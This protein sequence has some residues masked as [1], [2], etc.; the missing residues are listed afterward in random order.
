MQALFKLFS[1]LPLSI[2]YVFGGLVAW[3][4]YRVIGYRKKVVLEN[5]RSSFPEWDEATLNK[6]CKEFY[7][8]LGDVLMETLKALTMSEK[9]FAKRV[10]ITNKGLIDEVMDRNLPYIAAASHC[11]NWEWTLLGCCALFNYTVD[12]AYMPV[13]NQAFEH[14][15][16]SIRTRFGA[17]LI[18]GNELVKKELARRS[19]PRAICMVADQRPMPESAYWLKFLNK[20]TAAFRGIDSMAKFL[21]VNI[22][23][24]A[25]K[26]K[27]RGY[28]EITLHLIGEPPYE[29][30]EF[31]ILHR[32]YALTEQTIREDPSAWL[33]THKRWKDPKPKDA[34]V[35]TS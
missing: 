5:M 9:E 22:Y 34:V 16:Y 1:R 32:F 31:G 11:G 10:T 6:H 30:K 14:L 15:M 25:C 26:R 7:F 35:H 27:K 13:S 28:Y 23:Y 21:K 8:W 24:V 12:A 17:N 4:S 20:E 29:K 2:L 19:I 18:K 33:W 3:L